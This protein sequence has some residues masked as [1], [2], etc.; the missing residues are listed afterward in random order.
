MW[1]FPFDWI[2]QKLNELDYVFEALAILEG[3]KIDEVAKLKIKY[4]YLEK[5]YFIDKGDFEKSFQNY[6]TKLREEKERIRRLELGNLI[7]E[8]ALKRDKEH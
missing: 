8:N 1:D 7:D 5:K 3:E 2:S 6:Q 4:N